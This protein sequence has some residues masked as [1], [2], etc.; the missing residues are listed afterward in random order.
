MATLEEGIS[1]IMKNCGGQCP[2]EVLSLEDASDFYLSAL[3]F[4][5][6]KLAGTD[7]FAGGRSQLWSP[8]G[9]T[10]ALGGQTP[11]TIPGLVEIQIDETGERW[12]PIP[13]L[14]VDD[15]SSMESV[16]RY[17]VAFFGQPVRYRLSWDPT[18]A[19]DVLRHW[20]EPDAEIL[21]TLQDT[22]ALPRTF[23]QNMVPMRATLFEAFPQLVLRDPARYKDFVNLKTRLYS[24]QLGEW[25]AQFDSFV[26]EPPDRGEFT[27]APFNEG[28]ESDGSNAINRYPWDI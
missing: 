14:N 6:Q 24:S 18:Q 23:F 7:H 12:A 2:P 19:S 27:R 15:I 21:G 4:Y 17:A 8:G 22:P 25:D 1:Q 20:T 11:Q 13:I 5:L 9:K 10:G 26:Y 16:G 28:R 3:D